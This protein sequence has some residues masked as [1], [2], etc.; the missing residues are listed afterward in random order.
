[1]RTSVLL[2]LLLATFVAS[3]AGIVIT[4]KV[5]V[6]RASRGCHGAGLC[7]IETTTEGQSRAPVRMELLEGGNKLRVS[8][9]PE[10]LQSFP[11]EVRSEILQGYFNQPEA[12]TLPAETGTALGAKTTL[13]LQPGRYEA[14]KSGSDVVVVFDISPAKA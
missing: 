7:R 6:G 4:T 1:M 3:R 12:L 13:S 10:A 11:E 14:K 5:T 9:S 8:F 2:L